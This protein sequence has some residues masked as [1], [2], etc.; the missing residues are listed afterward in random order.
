MHAQLITLPTKAQKTLQLA[1]KNIH[2]TL[3]QYPLQRKWSDLPR[4]VPVI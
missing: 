4:Y 2:A 1:D 3:L